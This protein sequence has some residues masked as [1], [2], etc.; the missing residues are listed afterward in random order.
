MI[1]LFPTCHKSDFKQILDFNTLL[2]NGLVIENIL[3]IIIKKI[4]KIK[5]KF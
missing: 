5:S 3:K 1:I 4:A 2:R